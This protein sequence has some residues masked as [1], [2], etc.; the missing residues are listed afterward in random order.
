MKKVAIILSGC[1]VYD[2]AEIHE[3]VLTMLAVRLAGASYHCFAPDKT[4][5]HVINHLTG[6]P[7][8]DETRNVLVESARIARGDIQPLSDCHARDFDVCL[9]PGGFGAAKNLCS[10][11]TEGSAMSVDS[12]VVRVCREF[13]QAS[14][15]LGYA[16]I[17]PAM[18]AKIHGEGISVTIGNDTETATALENMGAKHVNCEVNDVVLDKAHKVV[19]TPAYM[20][21]TNIEQA[22]EGIQKWVMQVLALAEKHHSS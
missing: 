6:Q 22:W 4:Q 5:L 14:K 12:E 3:A 13:N 9:V 16:C 1:G 11:A 21:A 17:S 8:H 15:P 18:V 20:L 2:G 19:T 10:F 7:Q